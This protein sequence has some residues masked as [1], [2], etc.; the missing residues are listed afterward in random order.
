LA[1]KTRVHY[2]FVSRE[3]QEKTLSGKEAGSQEQEAEKNPHPNRFI[4]LGIS[5]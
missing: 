3:R 5:R 1:G 4:D 2:R